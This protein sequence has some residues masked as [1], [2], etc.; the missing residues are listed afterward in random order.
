M[1]LAT[2][3]RAFSAANGDTR[4][5]NQKLPKSLP[6]QDISHQRKRNQ[7]VFLKAS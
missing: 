4:N 1:E 7:S 2:L 6:I 3:L 5:C